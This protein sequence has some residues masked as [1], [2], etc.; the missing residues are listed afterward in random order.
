MPK[1]EIAPNIFVES[2]DDVNYGYRHCCGSFIIKLSDGE[3]IHIKDRNDVQRTVDY[4]RSLSDAPLDPK[5]KIHPDIAR[6]MGDRR[7][8]QNIFN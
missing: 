7:A 5:M 2:W 4:W 6:W 1:V 3:E 8:G